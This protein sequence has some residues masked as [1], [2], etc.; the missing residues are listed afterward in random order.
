MKKYKLKMYVAGD[1]SESR[2]EIDKVKKVLR[3]RV[4][5]DHGFEVI[6]VQV[7]PQIAEEENVLITPLVERKSPAP[8]KR[9]VG[10]LLDEE[11][12]LEGLDLFSKET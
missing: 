1:T 8:I 11:K 4:G 3:E 10:K 2:D 5:E 12:F 9:V 6:D 7:D